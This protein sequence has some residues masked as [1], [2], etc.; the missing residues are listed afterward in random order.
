MSD[1][2][3]TSDTTE[4][5]NL[6]VTEAASQIEGMLSAPEDST[7][8]PEVVEEPVIRDAKP[9]EAMNELSAELQEKADKINQE[10]E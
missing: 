3:M 5:G 4:S 6:T 10:N 9:E 8:Q 7:E 2:T 1:D